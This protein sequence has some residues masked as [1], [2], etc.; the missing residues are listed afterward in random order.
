MKNACD[1]D[2]GYWRCR[3]L[4]RVEIERECESCHSTVKQRVL[5]DQNKE[6]KV[7]VLSWSGSCPVCR[8][9][10][11]KPEPSEVSGDKKATAKDLVS[12][13]RKITYAAYAT[14]TKEATLILRNLEHFPMIREGFFEEYLF[15]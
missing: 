10:P 2:N 11:S 14:P 12:V 9:F 5:F 1:V 6:G 15:W 3:R 8:G 4:K 7:T 13:M